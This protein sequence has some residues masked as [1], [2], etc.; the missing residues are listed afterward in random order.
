M[1]GETSFAADPA[2]APLRELPRVVSMQD[3]VPLISIVIPVHNESGNVVA[4]LEEVAAAFAG[5]LDFEAV[6]VDDC[7]ADDT[8]QLL[9]AQRARWRW[10]RVLHH[11]RNAGQSTALLNGARAARGRWIGTLDGDGQNDPADLLRMVAELT[12]RDDPE[13]KLLQGWR[14]QRQD[15]G[16][17]RLSS[18]IA[19]AVRGGLLADQAR[20]SGCGIRVID[21][22]LLLRL[23]YFDH[24]HRFIPALVAQAG[25]KL[26]NVAV[27]HRPRQ[28]GQSH[29][30]L[31]DRLW[32]G[33][34]DLLGVAWLG[35]RS[36]PV[37][38]IEKPRGRV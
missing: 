29:Y 5:R 36:R 11:Q 23:P 16:L 13:L 25:W 24:M 26:D 28:A 38:C 10:L 4:L 2:L 17:K 21:R 32:V 37:L 7:S 35:R 19:N 22:E 3:A 1:Y 14:W 34:V 6:V 15:T 31:W 27:N 33:I 12:Q 30:G 20:D 18:K 9:D 8:R